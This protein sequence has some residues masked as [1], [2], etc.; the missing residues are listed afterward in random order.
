[1]A[2]DCSGLGVLIWCREA[3]TFNPVL[4]II[5]AKWE[6]LR[7]GLRAMKK[8]ARWL[9]VSFVLSLGLGVSACDPVTLGT[10]EA[11]SVMG[12]DKTVVDHMISI[13]SGKNCST[14]RKEQGLTYCVEDMPKIR[15]NIY[16]YRD[17]GG[18]TCYDRV[19]PHG[20]N[21][22]QQQVDRNAHNLAK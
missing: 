18:V 8:Y 2:N 16:C 9:L 21:Q 12:S 4:T 13:G 10:F 22:Q 1:M 11:A 14:I 17:L 19:D 20:P 6:M 7:G 15:Q 3:I 5:E